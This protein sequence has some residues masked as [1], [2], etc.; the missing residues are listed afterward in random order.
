MR[1]RPRPCRCPLRGL[2]AASAGLQQLR[3]ALTLRCHGRG[4]GSHR[5]SHELGM[6]GVPRLTNFIANYNHPLELVPSDRGDQFQGAITIGPN[7]DG[8]DSG[9]NLGSR[10]N[11]STAF[12]PPQ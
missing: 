11:F 3:S 10:S 9:P 12:G 4:T 1:R 5:I 2:R 8:T 7:F 6:S